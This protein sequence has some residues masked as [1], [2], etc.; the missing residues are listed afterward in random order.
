MLKA[1]VQGKLKL[2]RSDTPV[3]ESWD[4]RSVGVDFESPKGTYSFIIVL[5][6]GEVSHIDS[7]R[8]P[9]GKSWHHPI[10]LSIKDNPYGELDAEE[11]EQL[12]RILTRVQGK[13]I[14]VKQGWYVEVGGKPATI[15]D[16]QV[17]STP[18]KAKKAAQWISQK[19]R[20]RSLSSAYQG[21]GQRS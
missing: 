4:F 14:I 9:S 20:K 8:T 3:V 21:R 2:K 13:S 10:D 15:R 17:F 18:D 19:L 1:V 12:K 11:K 5:R 6:L 16:Q 7:F